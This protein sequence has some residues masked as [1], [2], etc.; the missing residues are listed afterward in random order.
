MEM[1]TSFTAAGCV[2]LLLLAGIFVDD[3]SVSRRR[4]TLL[5]VPLFDAW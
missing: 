4:Q 2:L 5:G 1:N 3:I